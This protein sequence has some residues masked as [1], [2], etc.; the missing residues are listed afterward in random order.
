MKTSELLGALLDNQVDAVIVGGLAMQMH[1]YMRMTYDIDLVLAM[2]DENLTRFIDVAKR[3]GLAPIIPVPIDALKN[4]R[5]IDTWHREKGMLAFALRGPDFSTSVV[6]V[7]VRPE[8]AYERLAADAVQADLA[9]RQV[10]I[11]CIEHLL[12]M[13]RAANRSKDQLDIV[14][15]EKIQRGE[16][17]NA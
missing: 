2:N 6:D 4:A 8:I 9:G 16:D 13:K 7:L 1:G 14:A 3:L 17:P 10:K 15:L 5:Q 12:E 11:A